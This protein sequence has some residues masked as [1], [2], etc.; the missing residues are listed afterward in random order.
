MDYLKYAY[1]VYEK[2]GLFTRAELT[3]HQE[4]N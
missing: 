1:L 2:N 3:I 4:K